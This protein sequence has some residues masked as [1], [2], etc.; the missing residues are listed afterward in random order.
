MPNDLILCVLALLPVA[1]RASDLGFASLLHDFAFVQQP[2]WW[3]C[4]LGIGLL[5]ALHAYIWYC[6]A[7]YSRRCARAPLRSLGAHAVEVFSRLEMLGKVWQVSMVLLL[8]GRDGVTA[9]QDAASATPPHL[10]LLA[11]AY[12]ATG[13]TLNIYIYR[14]IG[15]DGV[16]YGFK[17]GR[18]VPWCTGF[19]FNI[20][21]RHPQYVGVVLTLWSGLLVCISEGT[22]RCGFVQALVA[23]AGMYCIM[24]AMEQAG[25]KGATKAKS[26]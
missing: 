26:Q 2:R 24:C 3:A 20:G 19:P 7:A 25:D 14:A 13:Q 1:W 6:S 5:Y 9:V 4:V 21:L 18:E 12:L 16:Y 11:A 8:L 22:L 15:N 23:W 10:W 17:L